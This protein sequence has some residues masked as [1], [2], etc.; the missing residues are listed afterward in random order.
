MRNTILAAL[1]ILAAALSRLLPHPLNFTPIAA[2]ALAGGVYL[3]K[4]FALIVPL[5]ALAISDWIIGLYP[6]LFFV[7]ASFLLIGIIG[8]WLRAHKKPLIVF[9]STLV[10]SI[11]F[12]IVTNFGVWL[13]G[14]YPQ[15]AA[16]LSEC[17]I[18]AIPFFRNFLASTLI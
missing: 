14:W 2:M 4:R 16:G 12:F 13:T 6:I 5:I 9:A 17:F 8:I 18:A 7:Y 1:L 3:D 11:L 15:T 10:G